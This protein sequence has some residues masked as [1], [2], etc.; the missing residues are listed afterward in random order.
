M[1][2][3]IFLIG[4]LVLSAIG[5]LLQLRDRPR[6]EVTPFYAASLLSLLWCIAYWYG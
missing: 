2:G 6:A 4:S 3:G 1:K 5:I